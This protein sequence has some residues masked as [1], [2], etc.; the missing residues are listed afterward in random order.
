MR[1]LSLIVLVF[2]ASCGIEGDPLPPEGAVDGVTE[3]A[4]S[5]I[6]EKGT[7]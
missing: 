4:S 5:L 3:N 1:F 7:I 2:L 6:K